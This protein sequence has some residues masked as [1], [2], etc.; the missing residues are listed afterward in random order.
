VTCHPRAQAVAAFTAFLAARL[1]EVSSEERAAFAL[2]RLWRRR[3]ARAPGRARAHLHAWCAAAAAL[4]RAARAWLFRRRLRRGAARRAALLAGVVR[5]QARPCPRSS[6]PFLAHR[7]AAPAVTLPPGRLEL[8]AAAGL[9]ARARLLGQQADYLGG[10]GHAIYHLLVHLQEARNSCVLP[11]ADA[12]LVVLLCHMPHVHDVR[13][14][15]RTAGAGART[16]RARATGGGARGRHHACGGRGRRGRAGPRA[17]RARGARGLGGRPR[18]EGPPAGGQVRSARA[19]FSNNTH[20][21]G[22][23]KFAQY[24][25]AS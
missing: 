17:R 13:A 3:A 15:A 22:A 24:P 14:S 10:N 2:Q 21:D 20:S 6:S 18:C 19:P 8:A 12:R 9:P 4:Q 7:T 5:V 11:A 25:K 16:H 23:G 1:L